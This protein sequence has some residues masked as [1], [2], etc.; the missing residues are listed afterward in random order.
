MSA[1]REKASAGRNLLIYAA[2]VAAVAAYTVLIWKQR[3]RLEGYAY[4]TG[5]GDG[6]MYDLEANPLDP[7]KPMAVLEGVGY[8]AAD[9]PFGRWD[10]DVIK[11]ARDDDDRLYFYQAT[12]LVGDP[13]GVEEENDDYLIKIATDEYIK[14]VPG[15]D[16][17]RN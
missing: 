10:R 4:P 8:F 11:V 5:L 1:N 15:A 7:D 2:I 3:D 6:E 16:L 12:T 17:R 13:A 9:E 14:V